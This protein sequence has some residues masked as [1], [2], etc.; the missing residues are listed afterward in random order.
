MGC[1]PEKQDATIK[2][3]PVP[4]EK[5]P[6]VVKRC[7]KWSTPRLCACTDSCWCTDT[8][9]VPNPRVRISWADKGPSQTS[10]SGFK[11]PL[12]SDKIP[13]SGPVADKVG[14]G[15]YFHKSADNPDYLCIKS[16]VDGPAKRCGKI[17]VGDCIV[18]VDGKLVSGQRLA[19]A[20]GIGCGGMRFVDS[21]NIRTGTQLIVTLVIPRHRTCGPPFGSP[22]LQ[23]CSQIQKTR[24]GDIL[25]GD[26]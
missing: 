13:S 4:I 2:R 15:A 11:L 1:S 9:C 22:R 16:M 8:L 7:P 3:Q 25:R 10:S 26:D 21:H 14:I 5:S 20:C 23:R 17:Q 12:P 24:F 6:A 18:S 19:G